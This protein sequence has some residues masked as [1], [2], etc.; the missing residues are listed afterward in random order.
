L[1]TLHLES[2]LLPSGWADDVL[3]SIDT[4]GHICRV[5]VNVP[6]GKPGCLLPGIA[7]LHSHAHQRAMTGL[8]EKAGPGKDSFWTWREK[9]YAFLKVI[10][11][12]HLYAISSMLYLEMLKAG[13]TRVAEFQ[14]LHHQVGGQPYANIAEMSLQTLN[15]ARDTG[16]GIT[17]LPVLYQYSGFDAE[18]AGDK[19][20]RFVNNPEGLLRI[21]EKL[22]QAVEGD[23]NSNNGIAAHSLRAVSVE[24]L[25]ELLDGIQRRAPFP[26]HIHISE[27]IL[28]VE[29]CLASTGAR[30]VEYLFDRFDVDKRWCLVHATHMTG[31][32]TSKL[33]ASNAIAGLCPTTEANLGDGFFNG[34]QY[35]DEGGVFGIGS[36]SHV[37][38]SPTEE[39][40]WLE[41]GQRLR[42]RG[43]NLL[44]GGNN[45]STGRTL[46]ERTVY[47]GAR[48]CSHNSGSIETGKRADLVV[49]DTEHPRIN[50][51]RGDELL[52]SW[53]F[54]GTENHVRSVFVGG[55]PVIRNGRHRN[56]TAIQ[57]AFQKTMRELRR[58]V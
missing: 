10:E 30:P 46:F 8:T 56:E 4:G 35:L 33:A 25:N 1:Q 15:A 38:V 16:I 6:G 9:M 40:R 58:L 57:S 26:V 48:A 11:P 18:P 39:L 54:S 45:R 2:A 19:Q 14:Y 13:Y 31:D 17:S 42:E 44:A 28:E 37:C 51:R 21:F 23:A 22:E 50:E 20:Q 7:N 24:S 49:L 34:S 12:H 41:Y 47:G 55:V 27:Q 29:Q 52:D 43:R 3:I 32:E 36:D 5:E 53:I